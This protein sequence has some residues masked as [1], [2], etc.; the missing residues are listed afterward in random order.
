MENWKDV[1]GYELIYKVSNLGNVKSLKYGKENILKPGKNSTGYLVVVLY[2]DKIKKTIKVHQLVAQSFLSHNINGYE[3]VID[4]I[5]DN[6]LNNNVDNLQIVTP[7]YNISKQQIG[8]SK[9]TGVYF[10]KESNKFCAQIIIGKQKEYL[11]I[12]TYEYDAHLAYQ[13]RLKQIE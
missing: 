5:D 9:Y 2:K 7:R 10:S 1:K 3:K 4:H 13:K 6:K 12:F 8:K 11:G